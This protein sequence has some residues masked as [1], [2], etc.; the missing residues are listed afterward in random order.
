M[1]YTASRYI[2]NEEEAKDIMQEG[3]LKAF[4]KLENYVEKTSFGA[5]LKNTK[6]N[7]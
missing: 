1:F 4:L 5:W 6:R 2:K 3:F 7:W